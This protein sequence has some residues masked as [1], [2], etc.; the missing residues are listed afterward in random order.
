[1]KE[2]ELVRCNIGL[3]GGDSELMFGN[4]GIKAQLDGSLSLHQRST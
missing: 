2:S 3:F 1:M 4:H